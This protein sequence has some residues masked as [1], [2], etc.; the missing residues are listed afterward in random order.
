MSLDL[1]P[2]A[3]YFDL[4]DGYVLGDSL[5]KTQGGVK[6]T[7]SQT[8][9]DLL[10]D[11]YGTEPEDQV[12]TGHGALITIPMADYTL[13]NWATA[14]NQKAANIDL[15]YGIKGDSVVG[16]KLSG[17]AHLLTLK[18][19]ING[20]VSTDEEDWIRFP[21]AAPTGS[22]EVTFDGATQRIITSEFRAFPDTNGVLY[23]IGNKTSADGGS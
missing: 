16:T 6:V 1:G 9:A 23:Y 3:V 15:V 10:S 17:Y 14:L 4:E 21:K 11:Q 2:C 13:A 5:G 19:Y 8:Y 18:K 20:E 22:P 7:F 12:I